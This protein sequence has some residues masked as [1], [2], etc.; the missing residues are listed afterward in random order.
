MTG[1]GKLNGKMKRSK[2][3]F[4]IESFDD[5]PRNFRG[6][7]SLKKNQLINFEKSKNLKNLHCIKIKGL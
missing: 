7:N 3:I 5:A 2:Q 1:V 6:Q 4:I